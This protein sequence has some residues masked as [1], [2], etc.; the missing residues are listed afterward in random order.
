LNICGSVNGIETSRIHEKFTHV[1]NVKEKC[2]VKYVRLVKFGRK[3]RIDI[4]SK[5]PKDIIIPKIWNAEE[6][7]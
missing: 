3:A 5:M 1:I 2:K 7:V 6:V 4:Y